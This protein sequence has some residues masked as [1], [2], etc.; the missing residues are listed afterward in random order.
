M[1][2][3]QFRE[4]IPIDV[5]HTLMQLLSRFRGVRDGLPELIKN[6][7]DQYSRLGVTDPAL[8]TIVVAVNTADKS[9][10][11][12]DFAGATADQFKR[13]E[14][15][16]DPT[17]NARDK[18]SDI[19]GGHGNGG[20]A[21]MVLG[22]S[23]DSSFES[24][25][26]GRRTRMGYEN[27][28]EQTRFKPGLAV[29]GGKPV[30]DQRVESS[31]K[32]FDKA[33][34]DLGLS[35]ERLPKLA[36]ETFAARQSYTI[37]QV[38]GVTDWARAKEETVRRAVL[39]MRRSVET[40]P[41]AALT[42]ESCAV[43]FVVDGQVVGDCPAKVEHPEAFP[44]FVDPLV[45]PV[46]D[47]VTDPQTGEQVSTGAG[48][49]RTRVLTLRTSSRSLRTEDMR[50][51]HLIRIRNNRNVV[52]LWS[53]ADLSPG[54][55]SGFVFGELRVP[56]LEGEHLAGADRKVLNDTPLVRGLQYWTANQVK[57][58]ADKIQQATAKEHRSEDRDKVNQSLKKLRD[59]MR[60]FLTERDR[61][62]QGAGKGQ[63]GDG[64]GGTK[65]PAPPPPPK[66]EVVDVIELEGK[67]ASIAIAV[68]ATVPLRV[69]AFEQTP[70]GDLR[71]VPSPKLVI[72]TD[73]AD[74]L[75]VDAANQATASG[76]GTTTVWFESEDGGVKS[77][78][79]AVES[80]T[81]TGANIIGIPDRLLLQGE[82]LSIKVTYT[83]E[84]GSRDDLLH[85]ASVD[86]IGMGR[87]SRNGAYVAGSQEGTATLRV[88]W[89]GN[90]IDTASAATRIGSERVPP[91]RGTGGDAGGEIPLILLCGTSVPGMEHYPL[92]QR[93]IPPSEHQP[94]IV[95]FDPVFENANVIFINPDSKESVQARR[96]KGGRK[97][98][99]GIATETYCQFI[100]MKCFEI[101][102][103]LWVFEP[104]RE[105]PL[106]GVQFRERFATAE[107]ECAPFIEDAYKIAEAIAEA[108]GRPA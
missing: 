8:R 94:T 93:T 24:C 89:G 82:H 102:K 95:D 79:V 75:Q 3:Y 63:Q 38:N 13:W 45:I 59:L 67:S 46:P 35:F 48:D 108:G 91:R 100:A 50:P 62:E 69:K 107:M 58:L 43:W 31:R 19:E 32:Q 5:P 105:A 72:K 49:E 56:S 103:R 76:G 106:T 60:E 104:V 52:G 28:N 20:K 47:E 11:V 74:L 85:D 98:M 78:T 44:G 23:T 29:E 42:L 37:A 61:G 51:L 16:S 21:F 77:N 30:E 90:Q 68:G 39:E 12:I 34:A 55:S 92:E 14:T 84:G 87:I 80:V 41:Q 99:A 15:W 33:L 64:P 36:Q 18:A 57:E 65:P 73:R 71:P 97:G 96:G 22:S 70:A 83:T 17:A 6:S 66:G 2:K 88:R 40:H 4:R 81:C 101:L 1:A 54:A 27:E 86:E 9:I 26:D 53:V 25:H 7:K 10:G